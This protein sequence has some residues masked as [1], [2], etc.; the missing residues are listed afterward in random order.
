MNTHYEIHFQSL[1][2]EGRGLCF[3]CDENGS[4]ALDALS[5]RALANY[6]YARA[7]VGRE[8][9]FPSVRPLQPH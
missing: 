4:V 3:P 7:V 5:P 8:F 1:Y 9:M 2:D 6:L